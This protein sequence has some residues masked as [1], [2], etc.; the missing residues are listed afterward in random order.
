MRVSE[1]SEVESVKT[2]KMSVVH[3]I[4]TFCKAE[5]SAVIATMVDFAVSYVLATWCGLWYVWATGCGAVTGGVSN[6]AVNYRWVFDDTNA[7]QKRKVAWRY[8]QVWTGSIV[9]NTLGTYALTEL[10]GQ[11]FILAKAVVAV[12]VAVVWNYQL[13]R[14]YVFV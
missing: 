3:E 10:S 6:C 2:E 9:L 13:Q 1:L 4:W 8:M 7:L 14:R 12:V 5:A 11:H